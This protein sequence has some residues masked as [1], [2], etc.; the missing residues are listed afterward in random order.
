LVHDGADPSKFSPAAL[1]LPMSNSNRREF[2]P[3]GCR[4]RWMNDPLRL[5]VE[6][7]HTL[8]GASRMRSGRRGFDRT[9]DHDRDEGIA[10][11]QNSTALISTWISDEECIGSGQAGKDS[12]GFSAARRGAGRASPPELP[13]KR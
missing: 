6:G 12:K 4:P 7:A 1:F 9:R 8:R 13:A 5:R 11:A 10:L 3:E 2:T